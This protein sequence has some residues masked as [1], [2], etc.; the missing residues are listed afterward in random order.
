M[1]DKEIHNTGNMWRHRFPRHHLLAAC[2]ISLAATLLLSVVPDSVIANRPAS[3]STDTSLAP[4]PSTTETAINQPAIVAATVTQQAKTETDPWLHIKVDEG[5]TLSSLLQEEAGLS[6]NDV[7]QIAN[8]SK[9]AKELTQLNIDDQIDVLVKD[10]ALQELRL[11]RSKLEAITVTRKEDRYQVEHLSKTPE[12]RTGFATGIIDSSLF[13]SAQKAGLNDRMT[14]KLAD[15]FAYDVDFAQDI[16]PGDSFAVLYEDLYVDGQPVGQ[17]KILAA[18]FTNQNKTYRSVLY[19][20]PDGTS[21][22]YT[23]DGEAMRK[24]FLRMP[25]DFAQITSYFSLNRMHPILHTIR[26][27]KGIDYAA[28]QG[29]PIKAAGDGTVTFAGV[30]NGFGNVVMIQ[31]GG[32]YTTV[33]GHMSKISVRNGAHV[34]QGQVIGQVGMTGLATAPHLHY[35]FH[36]NGVAVNPLANKNM[37]MAEPLSKTEKAR[38]KDVATPLFAQLTQKVA[39]ARATRTVAVATQENRNSATQTRTQ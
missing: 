29:T 3:V 39:A 10:G 27:H 1:L 17:G 18:E 36:V 12:V 23:P 33:Y 19:T 34:S 13:L 26:A 31:H 25:L 4:L 22:Y 16:Q 11:Q 20:S 21:R 37:A 32:A 9:D 5:D 35:E 24:Q 8:S 30:R 7:H 15:I 2:G 28:P 38:F 14:L 6:V